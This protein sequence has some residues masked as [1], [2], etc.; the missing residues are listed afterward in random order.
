M[1]ENLL[2]DNRNFDLTEM[3]TPE[4]VKFTVKTIYISSGE[5]LG[6]IVSDKPLR[7]L[8]DRKN[9]EDKGEHQIILDILGKNRQ[10]YLGGLDPILT[11]D[12][13]LISYLPEETK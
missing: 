3:E 4:G 8:K 7:A 10:K 11:V 5:L 1:K 6:T 9:A 13:N 2:L 12:N